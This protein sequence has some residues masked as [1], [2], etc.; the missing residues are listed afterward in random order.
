MFDGERR[1]RDILT[2]VQYPLDASFAVPAGTAVVL[3]LQ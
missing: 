1:G 2:G 3:E